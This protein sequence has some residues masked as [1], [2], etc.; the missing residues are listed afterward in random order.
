MIF[1]RI[2]YFIVAISGITLFVFLISIIRPFSFKNS[3]L[4]FKLINWLIRPIIGMKIQVIDQH[5]LL[6]NLPAIT[7]GNHQHNLDLL[8]AGAAFNE[9]T[10]S[11]VKSQLAFIP[12]FGQLIPLAGNFLVNRSDSKK[13]RASMLKMEKYLKRHKIA[14][15]IFPEGHRNTNSKLLPFKKGAFYSAVTAGVPIVPFCV[16]RYANQLNLNQITSAKVVVKFLDPISTI[17]LTNDDIPALI[18]KTKKVIELGV[19]DLS[20]SNLE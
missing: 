2:L 4:F 19:A 6:D 16:N 1:I 5:K 11:V 3:S 20:K 17:G 9:R 8:M 18:E 13:A 15:L 12:I 7:V 10:V 14:V